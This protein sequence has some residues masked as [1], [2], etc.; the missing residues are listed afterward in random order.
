MCSRKAG[1][2]GAGTPRRAERS[3]ADRPRRASKSTPSEW[4]PGRRSEPASYP[5]P[6]PASEDGDDIVVRPGDTLGGIAAAHNLPDGWPALYAKNRA[7][8]GP[9][10]DLIHPGQRLSLP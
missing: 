5:E 3:A 4:A 6:F 10:P 9:D 8:V 1:L 2:G 7:T